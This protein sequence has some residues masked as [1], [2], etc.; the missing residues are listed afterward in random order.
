MSK[1]IELNSVIKNLSIN[2]VSTDIL[3]HKGDVKVLTLL[4]DD[5][6][7]VQQKHDTVKIEEKVEST[8]MNFSNKFGSFITICN[9]T[10]HGNIFSTDGK[11]VI[12]VEND[13]NTYNGNS[14]ALVV[15]NDFRRLDLSIDTKSGNTT[16]KDLYLNKLNVDTMSGN[17]QLHDV[18]VTLGHLDTMSGDVLAEI[19]NFM[20]TYQ[21]HLDTM[22]GSKSVMEYADFKPI[23]NMSINI[24]H[25]SLNIDTM[26]GNIKFLFKMKR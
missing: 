3:I 4:L 9:I 23:N 6:F 19:P 12:I 18:N 17:V 10:I 8:N 13:C 21:L 5:E 2:T 14:I 25:H 20:D 26:S 11:N 16:I 1:A 7:K 15:P 22:S 24:E